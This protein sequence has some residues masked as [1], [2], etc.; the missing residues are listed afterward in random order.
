MRQHGEDGIV[1][2]VKEGDFRPHFRNA[3]ERM[4]FEKDFADALSG[5]LQ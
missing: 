2:S 5:K 4:R 1:G 3:I